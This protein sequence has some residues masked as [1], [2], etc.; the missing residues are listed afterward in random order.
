MKNNEKT[1]FELFLGLYFNYLAFIF[2]RES[3]R[4][5]PKTSQNGQN[6][7]EMAIIDDKNHKSPNNNDKNHK[8]NWL[9]LTEKAWFLCSFYSVSLG[10]F[11]LNFDVFVKDFFMGFLDF[12][13]FFFY[14]EYVPFFYLFSEMLVNELSIPLMSFLLVFIV[15]KAISQRNYQGILGV[16]IVILVIFLMNFIT[17]G[18]SNE[19]REN[20]NEK[21]NEIGG[22]S[23]ENSYEKSKENSY[24]NTIN[25]ENYGWGLGDFTE[26]FF[27][28]LC[29]VLDVLT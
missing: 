22:K 24:E 1:S 10:L 25:E 11:Y 2:I 3:F 23:N 29:F 21:S 12:K 8:E 18:N 17:M 4:K 7:E 9:K 27:E 13:S 14:E 20:L 15:K 6:P 26:F 28:C 19:R 16:F 5:T